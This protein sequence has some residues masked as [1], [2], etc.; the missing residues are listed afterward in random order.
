MAPAAA[1][2]RLVVLLFCLLGLREFNWKRV[3]GRPS[4]AYVPLGHPIK[5][6]QFIL[7]SSLL[8]SKFF[9]LKIY[10]KKLQQQQT[11]KITQIGLEW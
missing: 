4:C 1:I 9:K 7:Q 10:T 8:I 11:N 2:F 6:S 5:L 3:L